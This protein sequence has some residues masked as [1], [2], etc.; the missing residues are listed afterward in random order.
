[1]SR[2]T[3]HH[4][5]PIGETGKKHGVQGE[6]KLHVPEEHIEDCLTHGF[7][8]L[9]LN[10]SIVPYYI[11]GLR[12][13]GDYLVKL[14]G[15]DDPDAATRLVSA[16]VLLPSDAVTAV[17]GSGDT[18]EYSGL[19]GYSIAVGERIIGKIIDVQE[20][21]QQEMAVVATR[22]FGE[23]LIPLNADF[24]V[25]VDGNARIVSMDLPEGLLAL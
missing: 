13:T 21:P 24:I 3:I 17:R 15:I 16:P 18:L 14:E 5:T 4:F 6:L 2:E 11:E 9:D 19:T 8:F 7:I 12:F 22:E 10:G 1:M 20:Y 25:S 23:R